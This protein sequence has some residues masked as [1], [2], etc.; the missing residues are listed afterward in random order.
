[1]SG[2][3]SNNSTM[4]SARGGKK[5]IPAAQALFPSDYDTP[6]DSSMIS[7]AKGRDC[8]HQRVFSEPTFEEPA[9]LVI[10]ARPD[11]Y[12]SSGI[13]SPKARAASLKPAEK[14]QL[15]EAFL[16]NEDVFAAMYQTMFSPTST[17]TA[18]AQIPI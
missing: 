18:M 5:T 8:C 16:S 2:V 7:S 9:K 15:M 3:A 6:A 4:F 12:V 13:V 17:N 10:P 11:D 1:M 14:R